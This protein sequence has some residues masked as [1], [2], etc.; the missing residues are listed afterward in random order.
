MK[1][2]VADIEKNQM[3]VL[4]NTG[5]FVKLHRK[6]GVNIGDEINIHKKPLQQLYRSLTA[7]AASIL[8]LAIMG[9]GAYAYYAPYSYVSVDI[10]PGVNIVLNRFERAI[11]IKMISSD[12]I[13]SDKEVQMLKNKRIGEVVSGI[14]EQAADKG[15]ITNY[16]E[17]DVMIAVSS[18]SKT[19]ADKLLTEINERA[20]K[21]LSKI[22][23]RYE[24]LVEKTDM[25]SYKKSINENVSPGK[26]I[27]AGKIQ[28]MEPGIKITDPEKLNI[29]EAMDLLKNKETKK[30]IKEQQKQN[31]PGNTPVIE[32]TGNQNNNK[33]KKNEEK[34]K[35]SKEET[36]K[37]NKQ[38]QQQKQQDKKQNSKETK[39]QE[40]KKINNK[41]ETNKD[42]K[43]AVVPVISNSSSSAI[44]KN[45]QKKV[46]QSPGKNE[47]KS[48]AKETDKKETKA[49]TAPAINVDTGNSAPSKASE[50]NSQKNIKANDNKEKQEESKIK[51]NKKE[52][53]KNKK[54]ENK[55]PQSNNKNTSNNKNNSKSN[56]K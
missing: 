13:L 20:I 16:K 42:V 44:Q 52:E 49:V 34:I 5:D 51:E 26:A 2:I 19:S 18:S 29:S 32:E 38:E 55:N 23:S 15:L 14:L 31:K 1:G 22:S 27:L 45:V 37:S 56:K 54:E 46:E 8:I 50:N 41:K 48:N 4:T 40:E 28:A 3:I 39:Q 6:A 35:D 10:N 17:N 24:V 11:E 12:I 21:E 25:K 36:K 7:I 33:T 53:N 9:T 43:P 30:D 47:K